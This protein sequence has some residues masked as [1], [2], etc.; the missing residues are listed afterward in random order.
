M[1]RWS[2]ALTWN[3]EKLSHL[4]IDLVIILIVSVILRIFS[5][6]RSISSPVIRNGENLE[7]NTAALMIQLE[8]EKKGLSA[9]SQPR[10]LTSR[11]RILGSR[12]WSQLPAIHREWKQQTLG[13]PTL[14]RES[15]GL[16]QV[17]SNFPKLD[18]EGLIR[19]Q[20]NTDN[21][22]MRCRQAVGDRTLILWCYIGKV[23]E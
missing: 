18:V 21:I 1:D 14:K 10:P 16:N 2:E 15:G 20:M 22:N 8:P 19:C 12:S 4:P 7:I 6:L 3:V 23:A 5:Y 9:H 17:I 11:F 13:F